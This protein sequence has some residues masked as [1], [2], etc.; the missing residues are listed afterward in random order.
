MSR[1]WKKVKDTRE[2]AFYIE[3]GVMPCNLEGYR[4]K[5]YMNFYQDEIIDLEE[6]WFTACE[7]YQKAR[8]NYRNKK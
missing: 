4:G 1:T 2:M 3:N 7:E 8:D 6:N 5:L